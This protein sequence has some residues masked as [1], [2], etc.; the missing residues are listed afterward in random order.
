MFLEDDPDIFKYILKWM[1]NP[2]GWLDLIEGPENESRVYKFYALADRL[3]ITRLQNKI[4][5]SYRKTM[6]ISNLLANAACLKGIKSMGLGGSPLMTYMKQCHIWT[7]MTNA[8]S[9][10]Q[11]AAPDSDARE[12]ANITNLQSIFDDRELTNELF[13]LMVE[14]TKKPWVDP[15]GLQGCHFHMHPEGDQKCHVHRKLM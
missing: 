9:W 1:Y 2:Q 15:R 7:I 14:Y 11:N 13:V 3:M 12:T 10:T 4:L 5:D 8:D 6:K